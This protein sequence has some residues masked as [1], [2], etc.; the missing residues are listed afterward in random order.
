MKDV[1][2]HLVKLDPRGLKVVFIELTQAHNVSLEPRDEVDAGQ[3]VVLASLADE[4]DGVAPF[5]LDDKAVAKFHRPANLQ[6][7]LGERRLGPGHMV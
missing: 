1:R 2:P 7:K 6:V 3:L 4:Q 5:D